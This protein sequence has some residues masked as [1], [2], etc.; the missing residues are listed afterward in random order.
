MLIFLC[1]HT[2]HMSVCAAHSWMFLSASERCLLLLCQPTAHHDDVGF[3]LLMLLLFR[4]QLRA[5]K[6]YRISLLLFSSR[7]IFCY[8][9]S[10]VKRHFDVELNYFFVAL[11]MTPQ[12]SDA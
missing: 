2:L 8:S 9:I 10:F 3:K 4:F 6:P 1:V 5:Q 11:V 12:Y 7:F